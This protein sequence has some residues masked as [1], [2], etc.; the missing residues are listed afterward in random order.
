MNDPK[1]SLHSLKNISPNLNFEM[2]TEFNPRI[3]V[4]ALEYESRKNPG[5]EVASA[6][7]VQYS[8]QLHEL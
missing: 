2:T 8:Y 7:L 6:L 1:R 5:N 4:C 3:S